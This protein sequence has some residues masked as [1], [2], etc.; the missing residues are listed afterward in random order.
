LYLHL[1]NTAQVRIEVVNM[2][3][4]VL[5][6]YDAG[7]VDRLVHPLDL[8]RFAEGT[9]LLR[10]AVGPEIAVRRIVLARNN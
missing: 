1:H 2:L 9:Y 3:G 8:S 4:Q 10:V 6:T 5:E 7:Q